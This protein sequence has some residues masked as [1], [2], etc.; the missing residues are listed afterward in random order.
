MSSSPAP[1]R[2]HRS[3]R[4]WRH[5]RFLGVAPDR[6]RM[7]EPE[8][9]EPP[10]RVGQD[11][12]GLAEKPREHGRGLKLRVD[13]YLLRRPSS[14]TKSVLPLEPLPSA[15]GTTPAGNSIVWF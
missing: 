11:P 6:G 9:A 2:R 10:W 5:T 1:C 14:A 12:A 7:I 8:V 13:P 15:T 4:R 3:G